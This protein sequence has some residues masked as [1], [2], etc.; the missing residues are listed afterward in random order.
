MQPTRIGTTSESE[1][2]KL[3]RNARSGDELCRRKSCTGGATERDDRCPIWA[4]SMR[5]D[6]LKEPDESRNSRKS[7]TPYPLLISERPVEDERFDSVEIVLSM[8]GQSG[9]QGCWLCLNSMRSTKENTD[10][11]WSDGP[12]H[13][14]QF[15][16][17]RLGGNG[18]PGRGHMHLSTVPHPAVRWVELLCSLSRLRFRLPQA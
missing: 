15:P 18:A 13:C 17:T 2:E 5:V 9:F 7:I 11:R 3:A 4:Q 14:A 16:T 6:D 10:I 8:Y 1:T 12:A